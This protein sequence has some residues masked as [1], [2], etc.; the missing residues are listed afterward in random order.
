LFGASKEDIYVNL[1]KKLL[2]NQQGPKFT[3]IWIDG[4]LKI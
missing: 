3:I 1:S 2:K 4:N